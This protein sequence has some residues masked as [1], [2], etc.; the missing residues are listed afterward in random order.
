M[1]RP[2]NFGINNT[3]NNVS[4]SVNYNG[5]WIKTDWSQDVPATLAGF[6][7][8]V[9]ANNTRKG[10]LHPS[11]ENDAPGVDIVVG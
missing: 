7:S 10:W 5:N 11:N 6:P 8:R 4:S 3:I 2:N 9:W 1:F